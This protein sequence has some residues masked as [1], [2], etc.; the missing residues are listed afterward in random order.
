MKL[1]ATQNGAIVIV[2]TAFGQRLLEVGGWEEV[3]DTP[4][5]KPA[6]RRRAPRKTAPKEPDTKE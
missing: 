5:P 2:D 1:R 3:V 6:A 4:E